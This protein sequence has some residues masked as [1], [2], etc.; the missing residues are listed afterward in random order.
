LDE[1]WGLTEPERLVGSDEE[2]TACLIRNDFGA[3]HSWH[4]RLLR[5]EVLLNI[6][7]NLQPIL[8]EQL[9]EAQGIFRQVYLLLELLVQVF[10]VDV[11]IMD[12][13]MSRV[14]DDNDL[15]LVIELVEEEVNQFE[16]EGWLDW[17]E[18]LCVE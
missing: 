13:T 12:D 16:Q 4:C 17:H 8:L 18:D 1:I 14:G 9:V 7:V 11:C 15:H 3:A 2:L 10:K 6:G 5:V